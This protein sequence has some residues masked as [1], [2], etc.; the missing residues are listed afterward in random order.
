MPSPHRVYSPP[1]RG[2]RSRAGCGKAACPS[3]GP[4]LDAYKRRQANDPSVGAGDVGTVGAELAAKR[5]FHEKREEE[6]RYRDKHA[7][8]GEHWNDL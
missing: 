6:A 2:C 3:R 1:R 5:D 8:V 4:A 7:F